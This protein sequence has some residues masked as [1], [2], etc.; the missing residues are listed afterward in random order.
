LD[1]WISEEEK[2]L[3]SSFGTAYEKNLRPFSL[4]A[5]EI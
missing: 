5:S 1:G 4:A 3:S 2:V